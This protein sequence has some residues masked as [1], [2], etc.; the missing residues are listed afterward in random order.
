MG[1]APSIANR[2]AQRKSFSGLEIPSA[3]KPDAGQASETIGRGSSKLHWSFNN[4]SRSA[5]Q[6][7]APG[8]AP[9]HAGLPKA[10]MHHLLM[11]A[12][13]GATADTV[14]QTQIFIVVHAPGVLAVIGDEAPQLLA[15]LRRLGP[16]AL[17][18]R[19]D[20]LHLAGA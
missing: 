8:L 18:T 2:S 6:H 20:F 17:E 11:G 5:N 7:R 12:L 3:Q 13:H 19:D 14:S 4:S 15:Q 16:H 10:G 9:A 1:H